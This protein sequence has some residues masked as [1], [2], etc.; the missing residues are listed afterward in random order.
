MNTNLYELLGGTP[1]DIIIAV[2]KMLAA[3]D[4]DSHSEGALIII[5]ICRHLLQIAAMERR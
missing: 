4:I 5:L 2:E 3:I 1:G